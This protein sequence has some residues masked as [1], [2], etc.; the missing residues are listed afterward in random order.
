MSLRLAILLCL[1][2]Q[3]CLV[4]FSNVVPI[5]GLSPFVV[6]FPLWIWL[7]VLQ[8][9]YER[10]PHRGAPFVL[11]LLTFSILVL[12]FQTLVAPVFF[13]IADNRPRAILLAG[14]ALITVLA[15]VRTIR[16][17]EELLSF[18]ALL[19]WLTVITIFIG[20]VEILTGLHLPN[21]RHY[22]IE[23][24]YADPFIP[25]GTLYNENQFATVVVLGLPTL[26]APLTAGGRLG[27]KPF[28][29]LMVILAIFVVS[30]TDSRVNLLALLLVIA[31]FFG[32]AG[33][34]RVAGGLFAAC[35]LG[36]AVVA[37]QPDM[38]AEVSDR[39]SEQFESLSL[40]TFL[41]TNSAEIVRFNLA[42]MAF[43]V[44]QNYPIFG[45]GPGGPEAYCEARN[46]NT[47]G[48]C[49]L[50]NWPLELL[51]SFGVIT[52]ALHIL[53]IILAV[54][55]LVRGRRRVDRA[56]HPMITALIACTVTANLT[57]S[58]MLLL[59]PVWYALGF[60]MVYLRLLSL[61]DRAKDRGHDA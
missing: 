30:Q 39:V 49:A 2:I 28:W 44:I 5:F 25:T 50:H 37:L 11:K 8:L 3:L 17:R 51:A 6:F 57:A 60:M 9:V 61:S 34:K 41:N 45:L 13:G 18:L 59:Q 52:G 27:M 24:F 40:D 36:T 32:S 38:V 54:L 1:K 56:L 21:S 19:R 42:L 33:A 15:L 48:V 53:A 4:Y 26:L 47:F 14:I 12:L 22:D 10:N 20:V 23:F 43:E 55:Y 35:L 29:G 31:A 7:F 58:S 16:D 46:F